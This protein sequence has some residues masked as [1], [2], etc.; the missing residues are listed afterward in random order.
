MPEPSENIENDTYADN[1]RSLS[2]RPNASIVHI[3]MNAYMEKLWLIDR[4]LNLSL[5]DRKCGHI[6]YH[7]FCLNEF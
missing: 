3:P 4:H 7:M 1:N 6:F 5:D 2:Y